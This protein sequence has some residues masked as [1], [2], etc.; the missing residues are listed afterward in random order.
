[1]CPQDPA[2]GW[3]VGGVYDCGHSIPCDLSNNPMLSHAAGLSLAAS[4]CLGR[5]TWRL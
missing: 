2:D 3:D 4:S 5:T 1:M